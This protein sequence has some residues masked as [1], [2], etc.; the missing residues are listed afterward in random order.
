ME[1][2][3]KSIQGDSCPVPQLVFNQLQRADGDALR[4]ALYLIAGGSADPRQMARELRLKS[5]RAA[6]NILQFW[7][8]AGLLEP[9]SAQP[10]EQ[11]PQALD[12]RRINL[13][14]LRDPMLAAVMEEVQV[15]FGKVLSHGEMEKLAGLY[16]QEE[17]PA[18][19][20]LICCAYLAQEGKRTVGRLAGEL[21]RWRDAGVETGEQAERYL[22][23]LEKRKKEEA[24]V[25]PLFGLK[26]EDLTL[27]QK[28]SIYGW[29]EDWHFSLPMIREALVHAQD[30][31]TVRY[32]NGILR[33]WH[34]QGYTSPDQVQGSGVLQGNNITSTAAQP[35]QASG[36]IQAIFSQDWNQAFED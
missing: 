1:Y 14:S 32:V 7:A 21:A 31:N 19:M 15:H 25:A 26:P 30:K 27:A 22:A 12:T 17:Y 4:A 34:S 23:L 33:T 36:S 3:L 11:Q 20:I 5:V 13:E 9:K 6:E 18:D 28:R 24:A 16:L 8:G 29:F 35:T 2:I 10:L